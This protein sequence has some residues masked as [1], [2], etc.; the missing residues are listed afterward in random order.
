MT[1]SSCPCATIAQ[2]VAIEGVGLFT[3]RACSC[4]LIPAQA[5]EGICFVRNDL[6]GAAPIRA[7][8]EHL[9]TTPVHPAFVA[10][11]PRCTSLA[12]P[13][14]PHILVHTTE[15][16]LS[17]LAGLGITDVRIELTGEEV[18]I[19]DG[20]AAPFVNAIGQV[21][22]VQHD[23]PHDASGQR[24]TK[25]TSP[26]RIESEHDPNAWIEAAPLAGDRSAL[27]TTFAYRL[28]YG[29]AAPIPPQQ[30]RWDGTRAAY[31]HDIAPARTFCLVE[32][33]QQM[34]AL[35]LFAHLSP[36]DMLVIDQSGQP[37][38]N[39]WRCED[40]PARHKL[41][42]LIGDLSLAGPLPSCT[43]TACR[44]GHRLNHAMAKALHHAMNTTRTA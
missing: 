13:D 18:P 16:V 9:A 27:P 43:I 31:Q 5:G 7:A 4:T 8:I 42:D 32:E 15:H 17:A 26:I 37:V 40:E 14:A 33:A 19:L 24:L 36:K 3:A 44:S 20:S 11:P 22:I 39:T 6:A 12:R 34:Q 30:A 28:D 25:L 35:G 29:P 21:G 10:I 23:C 41:L 2:P 38:D 1:D